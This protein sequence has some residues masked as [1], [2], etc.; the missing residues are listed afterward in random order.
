MPDEHDSISPPR[1]EGEEK[2]KGKENE[3][4]NGNPWL[5]DTANQNAKPG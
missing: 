2:G 5:G 4:E 1:R 3:K